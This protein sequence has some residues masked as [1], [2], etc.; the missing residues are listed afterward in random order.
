MLGIEI[1][2]EAVC[3]HIIHKVTLL[4]MKNFPICVWGPTSDTDTDK[5]IAQD[6]F[7]IE[8]MDDNKGESEK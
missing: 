3:A 1:F 2:Y 4:E 6:K 8:I 7:V 5:K